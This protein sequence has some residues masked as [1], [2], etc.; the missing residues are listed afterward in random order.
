MPGTERQNLIIATHGFLHATDSAETSFRPTLKRVNTPPELN[1]L[2]LMSSDASALAAVSMHRRSRSAVGRNVTST[3]AM[4]EAASA[5][6]TTRPGT[7]AGAMSAMQMSMDS[8]R[9]PCFVHKTFG[10]SIN[11]E[12]VLDQCN[13]EEM[14]H[15]NLLQTATGVREVARQLGASCP[16]I[17]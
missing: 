10:E 15:H 1:L 3:A 12:R 4:K 11:L 5:G 2:N 16:W 7:S 14:T 17:C 6:L 8:I 9:S 13:A